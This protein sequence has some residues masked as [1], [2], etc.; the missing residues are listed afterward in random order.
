MQAG[1]I[2]LLLFLLVLVLAQFRRHFLNW[3]FKGALFGVFWGFVLALILEGFLALSGRTALT[4]ILGWKTAPKP[5]ANILDLGREKLVQ[6]LGSQ[7]EVPN[8]YAQN[9][10]TGGDLIRE[11]QNL[12]PTE[13]KRVRQIICAP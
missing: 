12:N 8:S 2:I 10:A 7:T 3:S 5:I 1:I 6:V 13:A 9:V 4:E 11:F